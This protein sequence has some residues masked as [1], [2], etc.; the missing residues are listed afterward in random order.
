MKCSFYFYI[1]IY[2]SGEF[3]TNKFIFIFYLVL[4]YTFIISLIKQVV[5]GFTLDLILFQEHLFPENPTRQ[6]EIR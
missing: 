2:I 1:K 6:E 5:Q 3:F 4:G